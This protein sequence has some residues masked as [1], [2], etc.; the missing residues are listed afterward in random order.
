VLGS[1]TL[2]ALGTWLG[3][4]VSPFT[5][6]AFSSFGIEFGT[7]VVAWWLSGF[8]SVGLPSWGIALVLVPLLYR[9][10]RSTLLRS[11]MLPAQAN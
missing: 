8:L 9:S 3:L 2:F 10:I 4:L 1:W 7:G 6:R 11:G 5:Q